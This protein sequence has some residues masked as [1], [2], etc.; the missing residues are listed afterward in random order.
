MFEYKIQ[1][2]WEEY[3]EDMGLGRI[4]LFIALYNSF[5]FFL[6]GTVFGSFEV[7]ALYPI[8]LAVCF[9]ALRPHIKR[10]DPRWKFFFIT[11]AILLV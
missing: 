8:L 2:A 5:L 1:K 3:H 11:E 6:S 4:L 10:L 9:Y 7:R